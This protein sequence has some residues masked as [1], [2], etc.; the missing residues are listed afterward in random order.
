MGC[1][2]GLSRKVRRHLW[3]GLVV[4]GVAL[5]LMATIITGVGAATESKDASEVTKKANAAVL[6]E[7]PFANKQEFEDDNRGC[8][9][10]L[11]DGGVI[12]NS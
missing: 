11:P 10:P 7:L 1:K 9:A 8:F 4:T 12:K 3:Q 5:A 2:K 6:K